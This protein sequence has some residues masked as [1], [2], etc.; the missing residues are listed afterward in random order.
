MSST[1]LLNEIFLTSV[2]LESE[3]VCHSVR[4]KLWGGLE[5]DLD[6]FLHIWMNL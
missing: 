6:E 1:A 4:S 3:N 5:T 2:E